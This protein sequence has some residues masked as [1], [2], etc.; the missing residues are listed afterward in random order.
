MGS[1]VS[2]QAPV[3]SKGAPGEVEDLEAR[4][5]GEVTTPPRLRPQVG[6]GP[7]RLNRHRLMVLADQAASSLSN[8]VV[9]ILVAS[10]SSPTIFGFFAL[11]L[12]GYQLAM[13]AIRSV[14]GEPLLALYANQ[15]PT[16][17]RRIVSDVQGATLFLSAL[18]SVVLVVLAVI[19]GT[20]ARGSFIA[21]AIVLPFLL[22]QDTWRFLFVIDRPAAALA[23]DL[24][25]LVA[26][27]FALL[28]VP[29][30]SGA[31]FYVFAWGI[32]GA[33]GAV[34]GT[35]LGWGLPSWPHPWKW[36]VQN[37]EMCWRYF[38][39]FATAQGASQANF[40]SLAAIS[41]AAALGAARAA[42]VVYG[43][44]VVMHSSLYMMLVPEGARTRDQPDRLRR[45]FVMASLASMALS[46]VWMGAGLLAPMSWGIRLF[47]ETWTK[48]QHLLLPMGVTMIAGG[49]LSGG[50][51]GLRAWGDP[52]RSL[53]ARLRSAPFDVLCPL[54]GAILG[55]AKGF[56]L[57]LAASNV[58]AAT[59][60]W[61]VFLQATRSR[62]GATGEATETADERAGEI[63]SGVQ[64]DGHDRDR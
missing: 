63:A 52:R 27:L 55:D 56:V 6:V 11:T 62:A 57:G 53:A 9:T 26:V 44:L 18:C 59:I 41:G 47:G 34:T 5:A 23:I 35:A 60:W 49:A 2:G 22:V 1:G 32:S 19:I 39:E 10:R 31:G 13:G 15:G 25:W 4:S 45:M 28:L 20:G 14:A 58:T 8:V 43:V 3:V 51:I 64:G 42:W 61:W 37:R 38:T 21:L 33:L 46:A 50:I 24:V 40:A 54:I 36:I 12:V 17:R 16:A 48:A 30:G 29:S 7:A